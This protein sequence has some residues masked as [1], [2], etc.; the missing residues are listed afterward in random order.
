MATEDLIGRYLARD[1]VDKQSGIVLAEA[2]DEIT[3][4]TFADAAE[5]K[6]KK[7]CPDIDHI[8]GCVSVQ[9]LRWTKTP[10]VKRR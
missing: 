10:R 9:H 3:E 7:L 5:L 6:L 8:T 2:G 4:A 1:L